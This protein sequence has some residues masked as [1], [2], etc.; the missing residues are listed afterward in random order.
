MHATNAKRPGHRGDGRAAKV[1][2][3]QE[4]ISDQSTRQA[5]IGQAA[6]WYAAHR[7]EAPRPLV[8]N[9]ARRFGLTTA[10]AVAALKLARIAA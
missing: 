4:P 3:F 7:D 1:D 5:R 9:L 8:P 6:N 10:E 2:R